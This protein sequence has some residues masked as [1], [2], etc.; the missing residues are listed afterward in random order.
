MTKQI[1]QPSQFK[2]IQGKEHLSTYHWG[3]HDVNHHFCKLCGIYPFHDTTDQLGSYRI[4][5]G[6][7]EN[8]DPRK[9][10]IIQFDGKN[11]L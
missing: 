8:I 5:L 4:N 9:L 6:C 7:V 2:L 10:E 3:D 11:E 1:Y